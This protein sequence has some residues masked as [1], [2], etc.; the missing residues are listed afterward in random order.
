MCTRP[1]ARLAA[2]ALFVC[3]VA[4]SLSAQTETKLTASDGAA[5]DEFGYS[6]SVSEEVALVGAFGDDDNGGVFS[7]SAYVFR[8]AGNAWVEEAKLTA[9]DG[10]A[11]N[12]FGYSVSVSG[13]VA[14]AGALRNNGRGAAYVF[15]RAGDAWVEEAKLTASDNP[16]YANF[17]NSV[18][19]SGDVALIGAYRSDF[20]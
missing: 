9:S 1:L 6:V 3:A 15:R 19:V 5:E 10:G 16:S 20:F 14:L 7:G 12:F 2:L 13:N 11:A 8:R 18:S 17:G 4:P